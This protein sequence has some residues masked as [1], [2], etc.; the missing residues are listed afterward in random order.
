METT[1]RLHMYNLC[2]NERSLSTFFGGFLWDARVC[3]R[4]Q[5]PLS[6]FFWMLSAWTLTGSLSAFFW[7]LSAWALTGSALGVFLNA[8]GVGAGRF[9]KFADL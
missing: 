4:W 3:G 9:C 7:M 5:V 2:M 6:A 1:S 8:L